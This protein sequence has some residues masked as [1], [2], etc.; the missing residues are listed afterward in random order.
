M[1]IIDKIAKYILSEA[2]VVYKEQIA[3][4]TWH[5]KIKGEKLSNL[6]YTPGQHLRVFYGLG[7]PTGLK[8]KVRT[9]SIWNYD[10]YNKTIDLAVC[11]FSNGP[12]ADWAK[13]LQIGDAVYFKGPEGKF[14]VDITGSYYLLVGDI[15]ALSHLYELNRNL[16]GKNVIHAIVYGEKEADFFPDLD[17]STPIEFR[18]LPQNPSDLLKI[19]LQIAMKV[20]AGKGIAYVGGD[21]RVCVE[22]NRF[23]KKDLKW[24]SSQIKTKPFW[25]PGKKGLE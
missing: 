4:H 23:F 5:I 24:E 20:A 17:G 6:D 9:Y 22:L 15:S 14:T 3:A 25:M 1:S 2:T 13:N 12:G 10:K 7:K 8:D 18:V 21:G 11:T 16:A 19:E